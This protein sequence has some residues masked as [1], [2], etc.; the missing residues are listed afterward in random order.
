MH[1]RLLLLL[2][3]ITFILPFVGIPASW[4]QWLLFAV[5]LAIMF[6]AFVQYIHLHEEEEHSYIESEPQAS[7]DEGV[8]LAEAEPDGTE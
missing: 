1:L 4:K 5:G 6:I 8:L 3:F 7:D 2:G